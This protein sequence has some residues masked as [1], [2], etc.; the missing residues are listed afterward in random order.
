MFKHILPALAAPRLPAETER[1]IHAWIKGRPIPNFDPTEWRRDAHGS[2]M[3][4]WDYGNRDSQY[5]WE[6][7]H[8]VPLARG[9]TDVFDNLQ[10]LH[11]K[12]NCRKSDS[13]PLPILRRPIGR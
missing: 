4:Y 8:V 2:A 1:K 6:I 12:N 10:P 3:R 7:D 11:W 5:G 9:G 13:L